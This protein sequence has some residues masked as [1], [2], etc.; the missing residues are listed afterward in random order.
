[1]DLQS[2]KGNIV[3]YEI[4]VDNSSNIPDFPKLEVYNPPLPT[5]R[6]SNGTTNIQGFT[7]DKIKVGY[8]AFIDGYK[9]IFE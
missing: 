3:L 4:K 8:F 6:I 5:N 2:K 1:M 7:K 9:A